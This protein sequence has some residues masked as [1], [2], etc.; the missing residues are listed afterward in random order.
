[1]DANGGRLAGF[2]DVFAWREPREVLFCE[3]KVGRDRIQASQRRFLANALPLR[4]LSEFVVIEM[5]RPTGKYRA[6][7]LPG[8]PTAPAAAGADRPGAV[9]GD[10]LLISPRGVAHELASIRQRHD[11]DDAAT[12]R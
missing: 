6:A 8:R 5:P 9:A 11:V 7:R 2:F 12:L 4:P 10:E 1:M 3:V